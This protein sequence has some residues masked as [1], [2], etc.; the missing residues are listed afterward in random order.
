MTLKDA[1][2]E[3]TGA[4]QAGQYQATV[5]QADEYQAKLFDV[6]TPFLD[7]QGLRVSDGVID[8]VYT[9]QLSDRILVLNT[10]LEPRT[11]VVTL[12]GGVR[13]EVPLEANS[14]TDVML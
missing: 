4:H 5:R 3:E 12:P 2:V 1:N 9:A 10:H 14:I 8:G 7:K 6:I 11:K 13:R